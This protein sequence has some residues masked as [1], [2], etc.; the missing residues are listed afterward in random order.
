MAVTLSN[1][2]HLNEG[3]S[4]IV[5]FLNVPRVCGV[6]LLPKM[7]L[8]CCKLCYLLL[9]SHRKESTTYILNITHI[10]NN[11][12]WSLLLQMTTENLAN[13]GGSNNISTLK[14]SNHWRRM[15][16]WSAENC[17]KLDSH[18]P[19]AEVDT[20]GVD[21]NIEHSYSIY[22]RSNLSKWKP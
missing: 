5:V 11:I 6:G 2:P 13:K 12:W 4:I 1:C 3:A 19:T 8:R 15:G 7:H 17:I 16:H 22:G 18:M 21:I 14:L 20:C 9:S 10:D